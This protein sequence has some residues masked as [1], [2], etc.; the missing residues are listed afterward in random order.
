MLA[1]VNVSAPLIWPDVGAKVAQNEELGRF[2]FKVFTTNGTRHA[3]RL[4]YR[5]V[6]SWFG[7]GILFEVAHG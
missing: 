4:T 1:N 3:P 7:G 5:V 2:V 6:G